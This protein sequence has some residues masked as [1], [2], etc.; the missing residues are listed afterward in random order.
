[1][2]AA[3]TEVLDLCTPAASAPA[4]PHPPNASTRSSPAASARARRGLPG[5]IPAS[6][7]PRPRASRLTSPPADGSGASWSLTGAGRQAVKTCRDGASS[8]RLPR[9]REGSVPNDEGLDGSGRPRPSRGAN[10]SRNQIRALHALLPSGRPAVA[11]SSPVCCA[12]RLMPPTDGVGRHLVLV[13]SSRSLPR[14]DHAR[15]RRRGPAAATSPCCCFPLGPWRRRVV[16]SAAA[17]GELPV[18]PRTTG[19]LHPEA[20]AGHVD[21]AKA[22]RRREPTK[23]Y[24]P[25]V[26]EAILTRGRRSQAAAADRRLDQSR[27]VS[28][29]AG[30]NAASK[31]SP[32]SPKL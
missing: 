18:V 16:Y 5:G 20:D 14:R 13:P 10:A 22:A 32:S 11:G 26:S 24:E 17:S 2:N 23:A 27:P 28:S 25:P 1:M 30:A 15:A 8:R 29:I 19:T 31:P 6:W 9:R 7:S 4:A 21:A 3:T 12:G